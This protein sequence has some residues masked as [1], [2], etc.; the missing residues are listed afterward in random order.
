VPDD[1]RLEQLRARTRYAPAEAEPGVFK[2]WDDAG[3]FHPEPE[4]DSRENFSIAIPPPNVTGVLHMGHALN[5]SIQDSLIRLRRM[6]GRRSK[7]IFGTDHA[8]IAT[9]VQV[10]KQLTAEGSSRQE[11]G[12]DAF[13]ERVWNWREQYG[14]RIVEQFKRLGASAD[15]Q[16][17]RFTMDGEY[18]RAVMH[19]F[20]RLYEKGLPN[21]QTIQ[22][23]APITAFMNRKRIV[24]AFDSLELEKRDTVVMA[25]SVYKVLNMYRKNRA[26]Y[27]M[28]PNATLGGDSDCS[29]LLTFDDIAR[30]V[31]GHKRVHIPKCMMQ[32]GRGLY[33]DIGG[34]TLEQFMRKTGVK[35]TVLHK[36]DTKFA[37][38]LLW[39]NC[40]LKN[41]VEDYV[42]NP[43]TQSFE[44][45]PVP[46]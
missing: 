1:D 24:S 23:E 31:N 11:I 6:Q 37:N 33:T 26:R 3:I 40:L 4:G 43:L 35:A 5:G 22:T 44:S 20:V 27:L 46:A 19:V 8:G 36:I 17:E 13:V 15:Y 21:I 41:Y 14:S 39:R 30:C 45:L 18:V 25:K 32:S 29:V 16:D 2:R 12:R 10:E 9:Q 42:Q 38:K 7:W 28:V 34:V